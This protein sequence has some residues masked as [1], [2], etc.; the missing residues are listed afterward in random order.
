MTV[1]GACA[2]KSLLKITESEALPQ[3]LPT[4]FHDKFEVKEAGDFVPPPQGTLDPPPVKPAPAPVAAAPKGKK[5]KGKKGAA[6]AVATAAPQAAPAAD[7]VQPAAPAKFVYPNRRPAKDPIWMGENQVFDITYFGMSAGEVSFNVMPFKVIN[8]RKVYHV[9]GN[10]VSSKVFS[11]FYRLNDTIETFIDYE[12]IFPHRFHL[13]LDESKQT[14]DS[15]ELY[16]SEKGQ[17]FFW[18]RC[19]HKVKGYIEKKDFFP[20]QAFSQDSLSAMYYMRTIPLPTGA[21][22]TFPVI[23]EGKNWEAV[24]T[25]MGREVLKT[26]MG[27]TPAVKLRLEAKYQGILQQKQ[28]DGGSYI[29]FSDDDRRYTLKLEAKVRIGTVLAELKRVEP[30]LRPE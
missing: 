29:W 4:D 19:D 12:G 21:Q 20:M 13:Q 3:E 26:P 9:K 6:E 23:S 15:L 5:G 22:I 27:K 10:A 1:T 14:R 16:D 28:G 11:V 18:N 7:E 8:N 17:S 24:V 30:G 2:G 25:V